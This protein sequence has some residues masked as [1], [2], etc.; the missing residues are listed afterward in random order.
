MIKTENKISSFLKLG[1]KEDGSLNLILLTLIFLHLL[2]N[3]LSKDV[4]L[5]QL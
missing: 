1:K 2:H 4:K 5:N 3:F